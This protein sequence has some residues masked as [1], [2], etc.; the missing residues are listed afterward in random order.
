M[1]RFFQAPVKIEDLQ[2]SNFKMLQEAIARV[3]L[4]PFLCIFTQQDA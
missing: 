2:T 3:S 1:T 4:Y